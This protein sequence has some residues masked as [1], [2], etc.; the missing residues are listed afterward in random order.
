MK[1]EIKIVEGVLLK[2]KKKLNR[3]I[4]MLTMLTTTYQ[5]LHVRFYPIILY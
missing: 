5:R 3:T 2:E 4:I 1:I